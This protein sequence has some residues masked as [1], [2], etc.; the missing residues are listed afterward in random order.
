VTL[1]KGGGHRM[2]TP[3]QLELISGTVAEQ[4][5]HVAAA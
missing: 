5:A 4:L 3:A 1:V 2:S